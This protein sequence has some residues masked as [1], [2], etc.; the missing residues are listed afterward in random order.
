MGGAAKVILKRGGGAEVAAGEALAQE[1]DGA[2]NPDRIAA[3]DER[4]G[5]DAGEA[6]GKAGERR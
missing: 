1:P 6:G 3:S 4:R 5:W 2:R